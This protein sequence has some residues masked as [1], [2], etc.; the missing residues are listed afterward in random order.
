ALGLPA[1][2]FWMRAE[3]GLRGGGEEGPRYRN[4]ASV[5]GFVLLALYALRPVFQMVL[6]PETRIHTVHYHHNALFVMALGLLLMRLHALGGTEWLAFYGGLALMA[7]SYFALTLWPGLSPFEHP[8]PAAWCAVAVAHFWTAASD[9]RSPVRATL[10]SLAR[11]DD[12]RWLRL[13]A[14]WGRWVL[15][16]SQLVVL[17]GLLDYESDTYMV[18]PLLLGAASVFV[19]QALLT[20]QQWYFVAAVAEVALALHADFFLPSWLD[21][22]DVLWVLLLLWGILLLVGRR[23]A[24]PAA[25]LGSWVALLAMGVM[26]HVGYHRPWSDA[27]LWAVAFGAVLAALTPCEASEPKSPDQALA[28]ALVLAAPVWLVYF[29][30]ADIGRR[31]WEGGLRAWPLLA[32][33]AAV[34]LVGVI[35]R[36]HGPVWQGD[37]PRA[38][39]PV[40]FHQVLAVLGR[41]G[42]TI[43]T[44]AAAVTTMVAVVLQ[45]LHYGWALAPA[46]LALLCAL[47]VGL[48]FAWYHEGESKQSPLGFAVAELCLFALLA[49]G[50]RQLLLTTSL[51]SYEYDVWASLAASLVI[52]GAKQA[53]DDRPRAL[54]PP[55]TTTL[56]GLPVLAI[57]WTLVHH[58]GSDVA[59]VVV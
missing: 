4:S 6:F 15:A 47:Y 34:F 5:L 57:V 59:L 43:H 42:A 24:I 56:L 44:V 50:R 12:E 39:G 55:V 3:I 31:G 29:S 19:H 37:R 49:A 28:A 16:A 21:R 36:F 23:A 52:A 54:R 13:R 32:A 35:G 38:A 41:Y 17:L 11:L 33:T 48:V 1:V 58:L 14:S 25:T 46:D 40:L 30:Q 51:W 9:R 8:M 20:R 7:G 10:Q 26:A 53:L 2:Y 45:V 18:A 22:G 27:G